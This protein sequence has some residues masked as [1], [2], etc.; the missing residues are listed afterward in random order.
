MPNLNRAVLYIRRLS[1]GKI[2]NRCDWFR[3]DQIYGHS[4]LPACGAVSRHADMHLRP[5][6]TTQNLVLRCC[7]SAAVD[8]TDADNLEAIG[9]PDENLLEAA[10]PVMSTEEWDLTNISPI[11]SLD[12]LALG[13]LQNFI[14]RHPRAV[15]GSERDD[16]KTTSLEKLCVV[17]GKFDDDT[18][19][20]KLSS[21]RLDNAGILC[22]ACVTFPLP[23]EISDDTLQGIGYALHAREAIHVASMHAERQ[24]DALGIPVCGLRRTQIK[25]AEAKRA[26]GLAAPFP[27]DPIKSLKDTTLP[28]PLRLI[29]EHRLHEIQK[30]YIPVRYNSFYGN[31]H[32][33]V[34]PV[35]V[36]EFSVDR[37]T[38]YCAHHRPQVKLSELCIKEVINS[39]E[40]KATRDKGFLGTAEK[41]DST[42]SV[43]AWIHIT[44]R[45]PV[46]EK[47]GTR[48]VKG[49]APHKKTALILA[50]MH[51]ELLLDTLGIPIFSNTEQ[52]EKHAKVCEMYGRG[53]PRPGDEP[54]A[55]STIGPPALRTLF[56]GE[57]IP[58]GDPKCVDSH[59]SKYRVSHITFLPEIQDVSS[60]DSS[61]MK[62]IQ[63]Y[64]ITHGKVDMEQ[65]YIEKIDGTDCNG[66]F[67][68]VLA[69]PIADNRHELAVGIANTAA[70]AREV[71]AMHAL[72][73]IDHITKESHINVEDDAR[74]QGLI[75]PPLRFSNG[76]DRI[77]SLLNFMRKELESTPVSSRTAVG[78][79]KQR[80]RKLSS[81]LQADSEEYILV[82]P[83]ETIGREASEIVALT[84]PRKFDAFSVERINDYLRRHGTSPEFATNVENIG[85]L[86]SS[87]FYRVKIFL[88]TPPGYGPRVGI[89]EAPK[90][91]EANILA[92]MHC[93]LILDHLGIPLFDHEVLQKKHAMAA[94]KHKRFAP[95][96][97]DV[98]SSFS[99][100]SPPP[101][102]KE[103]NDSMK[104]LRFL[105]E[106]F[107]SHSIDISASHVQT[108]QTSTWDYVGPKELDYDA[109]LKLYHHIV[110]HPKNRNVTTLDNRF[111]VSRNGESGAS[112]YYCK[113]KIDVPEH[114]GKIAEA[115]GSAVTQRDA[116]MLCCMHALRILDAYGMRVFFIKGM[117][118]RH[119]KQV[120]KAGRWARF[121]TEPPPPA[122]DNIS[123][124]KALRIDAAGPK[125]KPP[126]T[127]SICDDGVW[128]A[129]VDEVATYLH[130]QEE[131]D[132]CRCLLRNKIP[133]VGDKLIDE[134]LLAVENRA[135]D[136]H[137]RTKINNYCIVRGY[138][139]PAFDYKDVG[140]RESQFYFASTNI[141]GFSGLQA[142]GIGSSKD[143]STRRCAMHCL[144]VLSKLDPSITG[145]DLLRTANWDS[146]NNVDRN[147]Q[148]MQEEGRHRVV[149]LYCLS[150][151]LEL[152]SF[153]ISARNVA[154]GRMYSVSSTLGEFTARAENP[155]H[156]PALNQCLSIMMNKMVKYDPAF[157]ELQTFLRSHPFLDTYTVL[158]LKL[159][160]DLLR[161]M[162]ALSEVVFTSVEL[163]KSA[164]DSRKSDASGTDFSKH[165]EIW[166]VDA[167]T[168]ARR[169]EKL[170]NEKRERESDEQYQEHFGRKRC[171]LPIFKFRDEIIKLLYEQGHNVVVLC[172]TTGCG[173]TTQVPQYILDY[174]IEKGEGAFC[175]M[176]VT[177]PRR[178]SAVSIPKG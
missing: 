128:N 40:A 14:K 6:G 107:E 135:L 76:M 50:C 97:A 3:W 77:P 152:P 71:C 4:C 100:P 162:N 169:N 118:D 16:M 93:E 96:P 156:Q 21:K 173:K 138:E 66:V 123:F 112:Y 147:V 17:S 25:Y 24:L 160:Q 99:T 74:S 165:R 46:P 149:E 157:R 176:L 155:M 110:T 11:H 140:K 177:Q 13:R 172:G 102:R 127:P 88:P 69:L 142:F 36:D 154:T 125:P 60:I 158:D 5:H 87:Q 51:G 7:S 148:V 143:E 145:L 131:W 39:V 167:E 15:S 49:F 59:L 130:E 178:I 104:W 31:P 134:T 105:R 119:A 64:F 141:P 35:N 120:R 95:T 33:L 109:K 30:L 111:E 61:A 38:A 78:S 65:F 80:S 168:R 126:P 26:S 81:E 8:E 122:S 57:S 117:Q 163:S 114:R 44:I 84:S 42:E 113:M 175:T 132:L 53:A 153:E 92:H 161:R 75:R 79:R 67:K 82:P 121:S 55:S 89:G 136:M 19:L 62:K 58:V 43:T 166:H 170:L 94:R 90:K 70:R 68:A 91:Q 171:S 108:A 63:D 85:D 144:E 83:E 20:F 10:L 56:P 47:Y 151:G 29:R 54:A 72:T 32:A 164:N 23:K 12:F 98:G 174:H 73:I 129:F 45:L 27:N 52:Q 22:R 34:S 18:E 159:S 37:I 48:D 139:A 41:G 150:R 137:A 106:K 115:R 124:P 1:K 146:R 101:L 133:E 103:R 2:A 28:S 9:E 116:E 86:S